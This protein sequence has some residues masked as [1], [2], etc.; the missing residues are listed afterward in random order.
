MQV[1]RDLGTLDCSQLNTD[2]IE[3]FTV[4]TS[5]KVFTVAIASSKPAVDLKA[6]AEVFNNQY[7]VSQS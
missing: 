7:L 2:R 5:G 3:V 4:I 6:A 1:I